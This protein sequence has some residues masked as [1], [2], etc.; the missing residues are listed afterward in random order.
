[1]S[2]PTLHM[3]GFPH[4]LLSMDFNACAYTTKFLRKCQI[5]KDR[6]FP[7]I[8]YGNHQSEAV[9][10]EHVVVMPP[11]LFY[12]EYG[13][14]ENRDN[15][16]ECDVSS[17]FV[18]TFNLSVAA[19]IRKRANP[20]DI[21]VCL[22]SYANAPIA[23]QLTD[24][25]VFVV[26]ASIGYH[27]TFADFRVFESY[28]KQE[29]QKGIWDEKHRNWKAANPNVEDISQNRP[30]N[31]IPYSEH[32]STDAVIGAFLDPENFTYDDNKDNY[33]LYLGR[34]M[35]N[36]GLMMAIKVT[37]KIGKKLIIAGQ[38]D[39]KS[40]I[41]EEVP[42]HV[43]LLGHADV[44]MRRELMKNAECSWLWSHYNEPFGHVVMENGLSGT[45]MITSDWGSFPDIVRH[46]QTG[47]RTRNFEE[48]VWAAENIKSIH[49]EACRT[50]ANNFTMEKASHQ[51]DHYYMNLQRWG[52]A[53]DIYYSHDERRDLDWLKRDDPFSYIKLGPEGRNGPSG[54]SDE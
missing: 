13:N 30:P 2:K 32:Q 46:G 19:E 27:S 38:G 54:E 31:C 53:E 50:W 7:V 49:S 6:D 39:F 10:D 28:G 40:L 23:Q 44:E 1:M 8:T 42:K 22:Y 29:F 12:K 37:E 48:S 45:P 47:F 33:H 52:N 20:R 11:E 5:A 43:E 3:V 9:C 36:K 17:K 41:S 35:W 4:T 26:E 51:Y 21:I 18:Y 16:Y 15:F 14:F 25:D 34:I 24:M